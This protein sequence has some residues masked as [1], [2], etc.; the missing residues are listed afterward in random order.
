MNDSYYSDEAEKTIRDK[1]GKVLYVDCWEF[2]DGVI[3]EKYAPEG[4]KNLLELVNTCLLY[5]S[6]IFSDRKLI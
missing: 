2:S 3:N 6:S 5:T 4:F 1:E